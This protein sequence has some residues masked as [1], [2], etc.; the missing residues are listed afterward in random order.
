MDFKYLGLIF[1]ALHGLAATF[2]LLKRNMFGAWALIKRQYGR[3]Q[4]LA[5]IGL[6]LTAY[7]GCVPPTAAYG[8]EVWAFLSST[9]PLDSSWLL[10]ICRC[11]RT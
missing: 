7:E 8:C 6:M 4:C 11:S 9:A 5:S 10:A 1:T 2:P 3:L